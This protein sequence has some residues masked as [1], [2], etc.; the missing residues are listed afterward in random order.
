V[1]VLKP[2]NEENLLEVLQQALTR[3]EWLNTKTIEL[4]ETKA[5]LT[6]SGGDARK[7]LNLLEL[8]VDALAPSSSPGGGERHSQGHL[9]ENVANN[10]NSSQSGP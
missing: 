5:L 6:L 2:L 3:D 1:Y 4:K 9:K 8:V 10:L 7:L